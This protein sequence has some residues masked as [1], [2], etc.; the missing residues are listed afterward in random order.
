MDRNRIQCKIND[1]HVAGEHIL[2]SIC[3]QYNVLR[4]FII[5]AIMRRGA[6]ELVYPNWGR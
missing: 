3:V 4:S 2:G 6:G 1:A 5:D